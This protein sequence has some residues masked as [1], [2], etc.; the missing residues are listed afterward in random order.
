MKP[1]L[2]YILLSLAADD[3]HGSGIVR[4]VLALTDGALKLW[5]ATLYGS[6]DELCEQGW[7]RELDRPPAGADAAGHKRWFGITPSGRRA[8]AAELARLQSMVT[9]AQRRLAPNRGKA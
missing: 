4:D 2:Y 5:P 6:L 9:V 7:I 1:P 8:V 3:R